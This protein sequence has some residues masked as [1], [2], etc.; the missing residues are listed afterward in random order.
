M[1]RHHRLTWVLTTLLF[2]SGLM[3]QEQGSEPPD[4]TFFETLDV[5]LI[6]VE[7]FVTDKK[8][9]P[10]TD[11]ERED[12]ELYV[13][14]R[15]IAITNFYAVDAGEPSLPQEA[16]ESAM[17]ETVEPAPSVPVPAIPENQR[18]HLVVYV[19]NFNIRPLNRNP[20]ARSP[21]WP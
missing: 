20:A 21:S 13:D 7:V 17:A 1:V 16:P 15:P 18:L 4:S 14:R 2:S 8:G 6:N 9:N 10:I 12:F 11:L 5:M 3:A 19:D